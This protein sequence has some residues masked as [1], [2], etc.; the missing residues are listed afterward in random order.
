MIL[1]FFAT[2]RTCL[3]GLGGVGSREGMGNKEVRPLAAKKEPEMETQSNK[4]EL[5]SFTGRDF[6]GG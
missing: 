6:Q 3:G 4:K 2:T 5:L 1:E